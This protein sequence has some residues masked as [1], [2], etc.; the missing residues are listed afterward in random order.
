M[1][2]TGQQVPLL[3]G[4]GPHAAPQRQE[5]GSKHFSCPS[6]DYTLHY[7][8]G[9]PRTQI[10]DVDVLYEI[11]TGLMGRLDYINMKCRFTFQ[12]PHGHHR[13]RIISFSSQ[14]PPLSPDAPVG[15]Q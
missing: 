6:V 13:Q 3:E 11:L 15:L 10:N 1:G 12:F 9:S 8:E 4:P 7:P 2:Q 14:A 5:L